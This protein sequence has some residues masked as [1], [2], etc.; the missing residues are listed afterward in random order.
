MKRTLTLSLL[1][2]SFLFGLNTTQAQVDIGT[3]TT[4]NFTS[5]AAPI[6]IWYRSMHYQVVYTA[7]E[8]TASGALPGDAISELGWYVTGVPV[9]DLPNYT[10]KMKH[11]TALDASVYDNVGLTTTVVVP[12]HAPTAGT[13][14]MTPFTSNFVWNGVSNLLVDVCFDQVNPTYNMSGQVRTFSGSSRY[15]RSDGSSQC[16]VATTTNLTYR[17]Q[18]R[19]TMSGGTIPSCPIPTG[20]NVTNL[21][22]TTADL[23]WSAGSSLLWL[24]EYGPTG[25]TPGTGTLVTSSTYTATMLTANTTYDW[26]VAAFCA[27]GD[28]SFL[29]GPNTF[30]TPCA[31]ETASWTYDVESALATTN[32]TIEDCWTSNPAGPTSTYRWN[33]TGTGTTTSSNTGAL[34]AYSGSKYFYTEASSGSTGAIAELETPNVDITAL[35]TPAVM[36]Y[37]HMKGATINKLVIEINDGVSWTPI[38]S[39]MGEQ[40][41]NQSDPW[42]LKI[43]PLFGYTGVVKARFKATRGTS[44]TGD[45]CLDDIQIAEAPTC[46]TPTNITESFI[47][48]D[49][50]VLNW[51]TVGAATTWLVEYGPVGFVQGAGTIVNTSLNPLSIGGL[52]PNTDYDWYIAAYCGV[53]DTSFWSSANSFTTLCATYTAPYFYTVETAISTSN[54]LIEDCWT[55]NPAGPTSTY[56]WNITG[57]GTT[58]SSNTGALS[59]YS[60]NQYFYTEA[61]SGSTGSVA[62]LITPD[63]DV[64]ALTTTALMF[65][66]HF[67]GATIDKMYIDVFDG[68]SWITNVDSIVGQHQTHGDSAWLFHTTDLTVYTG[69]IQVKFRGIKGTS[70]TGD[71]CLDNIRIDDTPTCNQP[72]NLVDSIIDP[73]SAYLS[74]TSGG[75]SN[76]IVEYGPTGFTPGSGTII[77]ASSNSLTISGL[78]PDTDYDWFVSDSCSATDI[79]WAS[80]IET[81]RTPAVIFCDSTNNFTYCYQANEL[82]SYTYQSENNTSLLHIYFNAGMIEGWGNTFIIYDGPDD[83]YPILYSATATTD[84]TGVDLTSSSSI[85]TFSYDASWSSCS[86]PLDFDINCCEHTT[87][88][89]NINICTGSTYTLPDGVI[90]TDNGAYYSTLVNALGC[91]SIITTILN[92]LEDTTNISEVICSGSNYTL[93]NGTVV[94]S[95]GFYVN[96]LFNQLSCDSIVNV[97]LSLAMPT[98]FSTSASVCDGDSYE[99][100]DG[101]FVSTS[102]SHFITFTNAAGCDS[103]YNVN[104]SLLPLTAE[105]VNESI[106]EGDN[107]TLPDGVVVNTAGSYTSLTVNMNNCQHTITTNLSINATQFYADSIEI[108]N[109]DVYTLVNGDVVDLAG[110]YNVNVSSSTGCDSIITIYV[111]KCISTGVNGIDGNA[112]LNIYPN[113]TNDILNIVLNDENITGT[114]LLKVLNALGQ[115][116]YTLDKVKNNLVLDVST[117]AEGIYYIVLNDETN[118]TLRKFIVSK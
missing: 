15:V 96:N 32:G 98:A 61:S 85:V 95:P 30:T 14:D 43:I 63:V 51:T 117:Y 74:W 7:A 68:S 5:G 40:Q 101:S 60:G 115:D 69:V 93:P 103:T 116:I 78:S 114:I 1:L 111:S 83:T 107:Y 34:S 4:T 105:T 110:E 84:V 89:Q 6:N 92:V 37:Y 59:A 19:L 99:M 80:L 57:T 42:Q 90:I 66:Y 87:F 72:T 35:T 106:C 13:Y 38:D 67:Y 33:I 23:N 82:S 118:T 86:T 16:G 54:G 109:D 94:T 113:P 8:L 10:I 70:F 50:V 21:L 112:I 22:A 31:T 47:N 81:F 104:L 77:S 28:T 45:I 24:V 65:R 91:D 100:P 39:I 73:Y 46:F 75:A 58:T 25:F 52:T 49:S 56:R 62:E 102:G 17:P 79:S 48:G 26:Y 3:G 55:S 2:L 64:S 18:V 88:T 12:L 108:C 11:T 27:V 97:T 36:F 76:W 44:Y 20:L 9:N 53:G 29:A 71:M 41:A